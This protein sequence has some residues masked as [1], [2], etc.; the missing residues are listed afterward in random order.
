MAVYTRLT[1]D[2]M[3]EILAHYFDPEEWELGT[4]EPIPE[5]VSNS[6]YKITVVRRKVLGSVQQKN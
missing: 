6:N 3:S 4:F 2:E 1:R 5:G